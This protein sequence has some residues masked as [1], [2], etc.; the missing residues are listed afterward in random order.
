M[1]HLLS[2]MLNNSQS[3]VLYVSGR[4]MGMHA[5]SL[6]N[7]AQPVVM[8]VEQRY[9]IVLFSK[10]MIRLLSKEVTNSWSMVSVSFMEHRAQP[11]VMRVKQQLGHDIRKFCGKTIHRLL[12]GKLNNSMSMV[13]IRLFETMLRLSILNMDNSRS[14]I[15][16]SFIGKHSSHVV[17]RVEQFEHDICLLYRKRCFFACCYD[18]LATAEAWSVFVLLKS[19]SFCCY[20]SCNTGGAS[21]LSQLCSA[22]FHE[23]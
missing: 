11:V 10:P 22:C 19:C 13:S 4:C 2:R 14:M 15:S 8:R 9:D 6:G 17:M 16:I 18:S 21:V 7:F 23:S 20:A 1:S 12:L 5:A 3:M